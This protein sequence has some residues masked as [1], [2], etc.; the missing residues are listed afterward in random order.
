MTN[1]RPNDATADQETA[2]VCDQVYVHVRSWQ[3]P[4]LAFRQQSRIRDI[5]DGKL[6]ARSQPYLRERLVAGDKPPGR[7]T[8]FDSTFTAQQASPPLPGR[9]A[10]RAS[11]RS[12]REFERPIASR[13]GR[14]HKS[15]RMSQCRA[16]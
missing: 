4:H 10:A 13:A 2:V 12:L 1:E 5:D 7:P 14:E 11:D 9:T 8:T 6:T 3:Q 16:E 15:F